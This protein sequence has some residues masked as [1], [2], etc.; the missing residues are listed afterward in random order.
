LIAVKAK[1]PAAFHAEGMTNAT[2]HKP[3][4][5]MPREHGAY[6]Q[7]GVS[8][9]AALAMVPQSGK[10]WA[11][12]FATVLVFLASEP[13]LVLQGRRGEAARTR[14]VGPANRRILICLAL[15]LPALLLAWRGA[16]RHQG[17]AALPGLLLGAGLLGLFLARR[18]HSAAGELLAAAAFSCAAL[19]VLTLG[20]LAPTRALLVTLGLVALHSLG[21]AMVRSFLW[22]LKAE[23]AWMPRAL[24]VLLGLGLIAGLRASALP[25]ALALAPVPLTLAAV[26]MLVRPPSP[27]NLRSVGWLLT[28]GSAL[29]ALVLV[30]VL[31]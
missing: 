12:A 25:R 15:L 5:L 29:G 30:A 9:L 24:P 27:R 10:A 3:I 21:T 31:R 26:W 22:S 19:P 14:A 28:A 23:P 11:Q 1:G 4:S 7:L 6:A 13:L 20:G 17:W 18:E 2:T 16:A 8:L